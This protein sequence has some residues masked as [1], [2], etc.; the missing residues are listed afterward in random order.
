VSTRGGD[1]FSSA[2]PIAQRSASVTA[3]PAGA[4]PQITCCHCG[5]EVAADAVACPRCGQRPSAPA[6]GVLT[7]VGERRQLTVM[8]CDL[9]DST[10]H[11]ARL[12]PEDFFD[13]VRAYQ[14]LCGEAVQR[15]DGHIAQYLGDGVLV[16]FG[17]PLAHEDDVPRALHAGL[18]IIDAL[19]KLN[20]ANAARGRPRVSV[21]VGIHT[22]P[23]VTGRVGTSERSEM[24]AVGT[25]P[26][27]AA[28]L[29]SVAAPDTVVI[30]AA[31]AQLCQ[32]VFDLEDLGVR[33]IKGL[34]VPER[35]FRVVRSG[36]PR[37]RVE[38]LRLARPSHLVP[39]F[40]RD[41]ETSDLARLWAHARAG[42]A[43]FALL[44]GE[45]GVGKS[46]LVDWLIEGGAR[47]E[48]DGLSGA[49]E[50]SVRV[51]WRCSPFHTNAALFPVID[52]LSRLLDLEAQ[53]DAAARLRRIEDLV[54]AAG[55]VT[56]EAAAVARGAGVAPSLA[57]AALP[58]LADLLGVPHEF[59][60]LAMT[61]ERRKLATLEVITAWLE[62]QGHHKPCLLVI[63]D[64]HW[65]D[66]T[67]G[68]LLHMIRQRVTGRLLCVLTARPN[69][70]W[71]NDAPAI[72]VHE[73][74]GL[75]G[76][77]V[78]ALIAALAGGKTLP[79]GV[80]D[81]LVATTDGVPLFV[82]EVTAAVLESGQLVP[83]GDR[84]DL[85]GGN[86]VDVVIP[87]SLRDSLTARLDRLGSAR[88]TAHFASVIGRRFSVPL[89]EAIATPDVPSVR[90]DLQ[91]LHAAGLIY[92]LP[93]AEGIFEFKHAL[94]Q[95]AAYETLL[96]QSRH[97]IHARVAQ[98]L[99]ARLSDGQDVRPEL[100]AHH[101]TEARN[102]AAAVHWWLQAGQQSLRSSANRETIA[103]MRAGLAAL[104]HLPAGTERDGA[105]LA[106]LTCL[107]PALIAVFGFASEE[108]G[109]VYAR[110]RELGERLEGRPEFFPSLWGS[111]VFH[112]VRG[113]LGR[114]RSLA[115]RMLALGQR[116]G[117]ESMLIEAHWTLGD[118][119]Y[120]SGDLD[121]ADDHLSRAGAMYLAE[122]H[123]VNAFHYGQ[124][125]GVANACYWFFT[126]WMQGRVRKANQVLDRGRALAQQLNHPFTTAWA[127]VFDFMRSVFMRDPVTA[128]TLAEQAL[129]LCTEQSH[130][131]WLA[132]A[133]VVKGWSRAGTGDF[134]GGV[135]QMREGLA[136]YDATGSRV[137][138]P[139][140]H[141][142]LAETLLGRDRDAEAADHVARGLSLAAS[143]G[144]RISEIDLHRLKGALAARAGRIDDAVAILRRAIDL[145]GHLNARTPGLRAATA[146]HRIFV[147]QGLLTEILTSPLPELVAA[148]ES[149]AGDTPETPDLRDARAVV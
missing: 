116:T 97:E 46:R 144:E 87:R 56:G 14:T 121:L 81:R 124:D 34:A 48:G 130:A 119:L 148:F 122:R 17:Y 78:R 30:S 71:P 32:G 67:T 72:V 92:S 118:A 101:F 25:T 107:G 1:P 11:W 108:V 2:Q 27:L 65:A 134:E 20:D 64:V 136:L 18:A 146:L 123:H 140:F 63:E 49:A 60:P 57:A 98:A 115:E 42:E 132:T 26:N 112:L 69:F 84:Y 104:A 40:G 90:G 47:G 82:E 45:A 94:V 131:F 59:P 19:A 43:G 145:A 127:L 39:L 37:S 50:A 53:P 4:G 89:L 13:V 95:L 28:R 149:G 102:W 142:L 66:P 143:T 44:R 21:R 111:W 86:S 22:G 125:P 126:L 120:W 83:T 128:G 55:L 76:P 103:H 110:S 109:R 93:E 117:D 8:F 5:A 52:G 77:A 91:K 70:V 61:P 106:L 16:Y 38:L 88:T 54:R 135:A 141:G 31:T 80:V 36:P 3:A 147:Q 137:A 23:V 100:L 139:L 74:R 129:K 41:A 10:G 75:G 35:I 138:Q 133:V 51:V 12:E 29:Q 58:L 114:A 24:L 15:F 9:A 96:K 33:E 105:E 62:A 7:A 79:D 6:P 68:D 113:D 85:A 99:T 73:L